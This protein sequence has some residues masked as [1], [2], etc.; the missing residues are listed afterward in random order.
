MAFNIIEITSTL[1]IDT[2]LQLLKTYTYPKN[3]LW[4]SKEFNIKHVTE[5]TYTCEIE[6]N[7]FKLRARKTNQRRQSRPTGY[8]KII[9]NKKGNKIQIT[10][11]PHIGSMI[12]GFIF[13]FCLLI[14]LIAS[15]TSGHYFGI[16]PGVLMPTGLYMFYFLNLKYETKDMKIFISNT[17][18]KI[19]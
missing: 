16:I 9:K 15:I 13:F 7:T 17:L 11:V 12:V 4:N 3:A 14:G 1:D 6:N 19:I 5:K 8:G 18:Q 2:I 10:V